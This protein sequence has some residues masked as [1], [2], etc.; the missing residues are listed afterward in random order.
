MAKVSKKDRLFNEPDIDDRSFG[1]QMDGLGVEVVR[2]KIE[3]EW[4]KPDRSRRGRLGLL[5]KVSVNAGGIGL[6]RDV[7]DMIGENLRIKVAIAK[8]KTPLGKESLTFILKPVQ[9][10]GFM[11]TKTRSS[12]Y[13]LGS[14]PLAQWLMNG[15]IKKG[16][17]RLEK[18]EGGY[19]AIA[20]VEKV[21]AK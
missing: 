9:A 15:G 10:G 18:I 13:R 21:G 4:Y 11:I 2:P 6:G 7:V 19:K 3:V 14:R 20:P 8:T 5:D 16:W 1:Q 12:S 17:Y